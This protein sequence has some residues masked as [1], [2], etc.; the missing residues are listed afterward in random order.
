MNGTV[1]LHI[2]YT[3]FPDPIG[4][5]EIY[6][7]NLIRSL[8]REGIRNVVAAPGEGKIMYDWEGVRV[9][10]YPVPAGDVD[11][12]DLYA[13]D[14]SEPRRHITEILD[15][16]RPHILHLHALTRGSAGGIVRL[17]RERG[18]RTVFTY[19]TPTVTCQRGTL[20]RRG[21]TPCDGKMRLTT[22][23]ACTLQS[24][25]A[26][27]LVADTIAFS[28]T[29]F[30]EF[31]YRKGRTGGVWTALRL[32]REMELRHKATRLVLEDVD[33]IAAFTDWT[34][35]VLTRNGFSSS[36]IRRT[37][38]GFDSS[39]SSVDRR[40][41]SF[42]AP[43]RF[44]WAGRAHSVKGLDTLIKGVRRVRNDN[45]SVD[46]YPIVQDDKDRAY[47][48]ECRDMLGQ[49]KRVNIRAP[50]SPDQ[51]TSVFAA[52]DAVLVPSRWFET[53][54]LVVLQAFAAG[55][56]VIGTDLGGI[57]DLVVHGQNGLLV[58]G[59]ASKSWTATL[60]R[61]CR[62]PGVL[63]QLGEKVTPPPSFQDAAADVRAIY[64]ELT[65]QS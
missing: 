18:I 60:E 46:V 10:R 57:S 65:P 17:A 4:G 55:V 27:R 6:V 3:F 31:L 48:Q 2:P 22:C 14:D 5:T 40:R 24:H 54:P 33:I 32:R 59:F 37:R 50:F 1:V 23:S 38:H 12:R 45:F 43:V 56:P 47:L 21:T 30:G 20:M 34:S 9:Y 25:G 51:A 63:A 42:E 13:L 52:Y 15:R 19:H 36:K 16:E 61:L 26:P 53:G 35:S 28:P 62:D 64:R 7:A 29:P 8:T 44:V 39:P 49:D 11:P 58:G 41:R